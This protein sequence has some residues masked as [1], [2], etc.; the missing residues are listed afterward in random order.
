[1]FSN[2]KGV[3]FRGVFLGISNVEVLLSLS[4]QMT[5]EH[6]IAVDV[7]SDST[8]FVSLYSNQNDGNKSEHYKHNNLKLPPQLQRNDDANY[9]LLDPFLYL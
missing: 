7:S 5:K 9:S 1:M 2:L 3:C 6:W 8:T 4:S